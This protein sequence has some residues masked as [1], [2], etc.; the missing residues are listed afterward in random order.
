MWSTLLLSL[1]LTTMTMTVDANEL[2]ADEPLLRL[3]NQAVITA[4]APL[5][6]SLPSELATAQS[7]VLRVTLEI[8]ALG[9]LP[10]IV[11]ACLDAMCNSFDSNALDNFAFFPPPKVGEEREFIVEIPAALMEEGQLSHE[12]VLSLHP[13]V[14]SSEAA[15]DEVVVTRITVAKGPRPATG[16]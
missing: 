11:N 16:L 3:P 4:T 6:V 15:R 10:F 1:A 7:M 14:A 5:K 8:K 2:R 12:L 13:V 9:K